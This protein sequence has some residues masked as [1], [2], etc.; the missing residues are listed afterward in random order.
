MA[1]KNDTNEPDSGLLAEGVTARLYDHLVKI[2]RN[3]DSSP[4]QADVSALQE[5]LSLKQPLSNTLTAIANL[6]GSGFLRRDTSGLWYLAALTP[7]EVPNPYATF[8]VDEGGNYLTDENGN[9]I[10]SSTG[11]PIDISYGGTGGTSVPTA[12]S[13]FGLA[14]TDQ[15]TFAGLKITEGSNARQGVATLV[16][17]SV[18]VANTSV[19]ASSRI[20]LTSNTDGG[21]PGWLRNSARSAGVSFTITSSSATDT[22]TVAYTITEP[23]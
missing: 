19:T 11:Y 23:G 17:G 7:E 12:R 1:R 5:A 21:T 8:L 18:V 13:N 14:T 22:S 4:S 15:P 6:I 2:G 3:V 9:Y 20:Q 16:A 10:V